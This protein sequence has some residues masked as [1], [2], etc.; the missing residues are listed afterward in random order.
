MQSPR[1]QPVWVYAAS[2][3]FD[4]NLNGVVLFGGGSRGVDQ[5]TSWLWSRSN[6]KQ[7]QT[8]QS[9]PAREGAGMAF[10]EPLGHAI[11]FGG[12]DATSFFND[13]WQLIP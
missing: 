4:P 8:S 2:A 1:T 10:D 3:A 12:Q 5:N 13:T 6:W 11:V 9:P 7:L